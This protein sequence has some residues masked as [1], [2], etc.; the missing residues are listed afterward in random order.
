[1]Q[2]KMLHK[3]VRYL[4]GID[5]AEYSKVAYGRKNLELYE[6]LLDEGCSV[7]TLWHN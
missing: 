4:T 7:T 3:N 6:Q 2:Q 1:M 5:E